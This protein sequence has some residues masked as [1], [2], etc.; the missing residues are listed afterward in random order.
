MAEPGGALQPHDLP[1]VREGDTVI[2]DVNGEKKSIIK[3]KGIRSV[4]LI[5]PISP[6]RVCSLFAL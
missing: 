4:G 1:V 2:L 6:Q 5:I 3:L